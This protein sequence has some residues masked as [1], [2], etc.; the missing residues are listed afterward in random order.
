MSKDK[1]TLPLDG[2][3]IQILINDTIKQ[4]F[5]Q[6]AQIELQDCTVPNVIPQ[7]LYTVYTTFTGGYTIH[8]AFC[9]EKK[10]LKHIAENML[11]EPVTESED[12]EECAKEFLNILCGHM[13]KTIFGKTKTAARFHSP[14]FVEGYYIPETEDNSSIIATHYTNEQFQ[15][16]ILIDDK[17]SSMDEETQKGR[18]K[19]E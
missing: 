3:P 2:D 6:V 15:M 8:F 19:D 14:Y 17:F 12:I 9:A 10:L 5:K 18:T 11:G 7:N 4:V 1:R 13:V 16:A